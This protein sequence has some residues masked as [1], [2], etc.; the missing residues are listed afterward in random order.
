MEERKSK[1]GRGEDRKREYIKVYS[2]GKGWGHRRVVSHEGER[3][4]TYIFNPGT[5]RE[6]E[7]VPREIH[8]HVS[9][10]HYSPVVAQ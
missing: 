2:E 5:Q 3:G 8:T 9:L 6:G 4:H 7:G 10:S 1:I